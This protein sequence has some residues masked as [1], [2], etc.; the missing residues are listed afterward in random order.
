MITAVGV[1]LPAHN[2]ADRIGT[3][4]ESIKT[5][6]E[7]LPAGV[8]SAMWVVVDRSADGTAEIVK[9]ALA[10]RSR[11][12]L[13]LSC[14]PRPIGSLRHRGALEVLRLLRPHPPAHTWLLSTDADSQV[15]TDWALR[16]LWY[17]GKG[18]PAVAGLVRLA[19]LH[20]LH[21]QA[22]RRYLALLESRQKELTHGHV[23]GANLGIRGDAYLKV[24]G[25]EPR[26]TGEDA[27]MVR[28][29]G[30]SGFQVTHA[31]DVWVSTSARL[32]GRAKGGLADL[33][34]EL[35]REAVLDG[36]PG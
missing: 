32:S 3:C 9:R 19:G 13:E 21:P 12:G 23:Y 6:L 29:L 27:D 5:A 4:L 8:D 31:S 30:S 10:G 26:S 28:R 14:L 35:Q 15:P 1:V 34:G 7:R 20:R 2:E 16:H 22:V 36:S 11:S 18:A 25:F 24:G 33:L 17:A